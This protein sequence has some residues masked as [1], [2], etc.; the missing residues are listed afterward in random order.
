MIIILVK[1]L[2]APKIAVTSSLVRKMK[3][4]NGDLECRVRGFPRS[5]VWFKNGEKLSPSASRRYAIETYQEDDVTVSSL[6]IVSLET[7]DFAV[8]V[9]QADNEFGSDEMEI[10]LEQSDDFVNID[11]SL[12]SPAD[13]IRKENSGP[14]K[15]MCKVEAFPRIMIFWYKYIGKSDG[16][17][18]YTDKEQVKQDNRN[19][20]SGMTTS[21]ILLTV[22]VVF[23]FQKL[24]S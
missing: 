17:K 6:T 9:C 11:K 20:S 22:T 24:F 19:K 12:S 1:K 16:R 2:G 21:Y 14:I 3:S 4:E 8:Y 18:Q 15:L 13:V 23:A 7:S 5:V 10:R